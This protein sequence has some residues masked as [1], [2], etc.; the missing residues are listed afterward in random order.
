V[1]VDADC[2]IS[3]LRWDAF[4]I[5][6][7]ELLERMDRAGVDRAIA[8]LRPPY[9][10]DIE[11]ENRYVYESCRRFPDRL[12]GFGW[13]NP[14]LGYERTRD[15][16]KRC[17]DEY[18]FYGIKFNGAQDEYVIDDPEILPLIEFAVS[19]GKP[20]AFHIGADSPENTHPTRLGHIATLFPETSFLMS[21][22]GGAALP[23]LDR[24]A[25][26]TCVAHANIFPIGS[27]I[28]E[29]PVQNAIRI[30]GARRVCFGSDEPFR[31]AR[32]QLA[33]WRAMLDD[34]SAEDRDAILGG[35]IEM[36]L[37]L[38]TKVAE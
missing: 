38:E 11:R 5:T 27:A 29:L 32:F 10:R 25:V 14:R 23:P 35:N 21:H 19:F 9:D 4:S 31:M 2:H 13:A 17:F 7:D 37:R 36:L 28:Y 30:L 24:S 20:V 15:T 8:W 16:I 26:D 12:L 1:I 18:G 22:L 34:V 3:S 33:G 6:A